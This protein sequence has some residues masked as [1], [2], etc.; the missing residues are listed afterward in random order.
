MTIDPHIKNILGISEISQIGIVARDIDRAINNYSNIFGIGFPK[1]FIPEYFNMTYRNKPSQ[2]KIK[3]ALGMMGNLQ[4]EL[5]QVLEGNT[6][7]GEFLE[8]KGE[9]LHHLGL[10]VKNMDERIRALE[11]LGAGVLMSGE[12]VGVR[13]AYMD[14]EKIFSV[15][16]EFIEREM[17]M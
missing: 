12:R 17:K 9:G 16:F 4:V 1:V 13:F 3:V 15:I 10:D 2:F 14:T 8:K 6:I 11:G 5:I 7:Y